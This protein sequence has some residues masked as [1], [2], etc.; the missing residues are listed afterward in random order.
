MIMKKFSDVLAD[1]SKLAGLRIKSIRS[2]ADVTILDVDFENERINI[3]NSSGEHKSRSFVEIE[4]LWAALC[5]KNAIHVD[6]ELGG[7]GSSRNQP[8]TILAN[9]P[10]VEWFFA[11]QKKHLALM[12]VSTHALGTLKMLDPITAEKLKRSLISAAEN[13][14]RGP[15]TQIVV[16]SGDIVKHAEII[17]QTSGIKAVALQQ[18][19]YAFDLASSKILL[20]S[21]SVVAGEIS[22]GTYLVIAGD[23]GQGSIK[24]ISICGLDF[25]LLSKD[26]LCLLYDKNPS[27]L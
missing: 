5:K 9:L 12:G 23:P 8:E 1:I 20:V 2:G 19:V 18:G 16:V 13:L 15:A 21:V 11:S 17:E 4:R 24:N 10:Y 27:L 7:S 25:A 22:P 6:S 3:L 26:G 14:R